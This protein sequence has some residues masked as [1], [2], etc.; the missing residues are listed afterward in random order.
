VLALENDGQPYPPNIVS[1][2]EV[3][4]H[5]VLRFEPTDKANGKALWRQWAERAGLGRF[6]PHRR[7][8]L[9]R[10]PEVS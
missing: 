2:M 6:V 10:G 8:P 4:A 3:F 9:P 7:E 1:R 5:N